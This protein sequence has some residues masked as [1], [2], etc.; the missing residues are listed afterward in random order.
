MFTGIITDQGYIR[1]INKTATGAQ[2]VIQTT[3][4]HQ[5]RHVGDSIAVNGICLTLTA[6]TDEAFTVVAMAETLQRTTLGTWQTGMQ[7]NL[8]TALRADQGL[9][10]HIVQG[11]VDTTATLRASHTEGAAVRLTFDVSADQAPYLVEKG[12]VALDGVSLTVTAVTRQT[13]Q[14][15]LIPYT[16]AHT[17][18]GH[19]Q[20]GDQVNVE[21]DILGKYVV[22]QYQLGGM[23]DD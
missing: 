8:E 17:S 2:L 16:L 18:L 13:V 6:V 11:H 3:R 14:V 9:D 20:C 23:T 22:R 10:G 5:T 12:A 15:A 4:A 7:V 19:L 1:Q 21:T